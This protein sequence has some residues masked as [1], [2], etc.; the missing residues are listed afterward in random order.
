MSGQRICVVIQRYLD[1]LPGDTGAEKTVQR[2]LNRTRL[3]LAKRLADL[4][5]AT[6]HESMSLGETP[7][8]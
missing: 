8:P 4:H 1:S 3:L 2:R 6:S 5:P 7:V